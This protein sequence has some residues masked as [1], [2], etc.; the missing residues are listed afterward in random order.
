MKNRKEKT[1]MSRDAKMRILTR[2]LAAIMVGLML[3]AALSTGIYY[4]IA[5]N[6]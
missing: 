2:I 5:A 3:F 6:S 4:I 1:K